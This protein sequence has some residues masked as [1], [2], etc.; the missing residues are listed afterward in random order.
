LRLVAGKVGLLLAIFLLT[1]TG[2]FLAVRAVPGDPV[3]S[4]LKRPDPV[5]VAAMR[6]ELGLDDS[7]GVQWGRYLGHFVTGNWGRSIT[8]GRVV[9]D[10]VAEFFP[11]TIELS[12]AALGLGVVFGTAMAVGAEIFRWAFVR[13]LALALGTIG[14]TV[15][16]FW[17]GLLALAVGSGGLGWF[18]SSGRFDLVLAPPAKLTG[19]LTVDALLTGNGSALGSALRHL[20]LPAIC[21][22]LFQAA[23]VCSVLQARL[24]DARLRTLVVSLRAR[25]LGPGRIWSRHILKVVSAP[26]LAVIGTNFGG[27]LGGAV[28]TETVFSWPGVGRYLVSAVIE[29]DVFVVE[30]VVLLVVLLVVAVVF[31][32][33]LIARVINPVA[34]RAEDER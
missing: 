22:S 9:T 25:G 8:S 5:R 19:L 1:A 7:W 24:Q 2:L 29:R 13:R 18:P 12:L 21:L 32:T 31:V 26:V 34:V 23:Y 3:A 27:L 14:L 10:D 30:N 28:L 20:A 16:V 6:A 15:P 11:A 4:R 17:V 33:D